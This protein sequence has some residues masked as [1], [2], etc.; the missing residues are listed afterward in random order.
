MRTIDNIGN[1]FLGNAIYKTILQ[2]PNNYFLQ[3]NNLN[4]GFEDFNWLQTQLNYPTFSFGNSQTDWDNKRCKFP[5]FFLSFDSDLPNLLNIGGWNNSYSNETGYQVLKIKFSNNRL[6]YLNTYSQYCAGGYAA[7]L[8]IGYYLV[9]ASANT[10]FFMAL[11][12]NRLDKILTMVSTPDYEK[13][14]QYFIVS[15][16]KT[17]SDNYYGG[18][19][20]Y[21]VLTGQRYRTYNNGYQ[22]QIKNSW[23]N[24]SENNLLTSGNA[25]FNISCLDD[26][27]PSENW[28]TDAIFFHNAPTLGNPWIGKT[29]NLLKMAQGSFTKNLIYEC[30]IGDG[31]SKFWWALDKFTSNKT[32]FIRVN[33]II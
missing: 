9:S 6:D 29:D 21:I 15:K 17:I 28:L 14:Y 3:A 1:C 19:H 10:F 13:Y 20:R 5:D 16:L 27:T 4:T 32:L 12:T 30:D 8:P 31:G 18:L 25:E 24:P 22:Y 7:S 2:D 11:G 26:Q 23:V 33:S